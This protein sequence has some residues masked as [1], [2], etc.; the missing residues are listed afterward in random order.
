MLRF[1]HVTSPKDTMTYLL[2]NTRILYPLKTPRKLCFSSIFMRY[3]LGTLA[4]C[5][6]KNVMKNSY[7]KISPYN[8]V[9]SSITNFREASERNA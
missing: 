1:F 4:R 9:N 2:T 3:Q 6:F 5:R 7:M 8:L